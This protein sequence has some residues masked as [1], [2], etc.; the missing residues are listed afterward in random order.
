MSRWNAEDF[1]RPG[2]VEFFDVVEEQDSDTVSH[3]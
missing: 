3:F 2:E 1:P